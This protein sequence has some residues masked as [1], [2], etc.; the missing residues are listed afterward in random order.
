MTDREP[1]IQFEQVGK[2]YVTLDGETTALE[3]INFHVFRGEF[4][5][6]LGP[7][8]CGKSTILSLLAGLIKPT[9]GTVLIEQKPVTS[10]SRKIG[11]MLQQD[12]LLNWRTIEQNI[13]LGLEIQRQINDA[14]REYA[15]KLLDEM[16]LSDYRNYYPGQLSGGM[17][18]RVALTRTLATRPDIL[19]LDEPFSALDFTTRL[20]LE[21]LVVKTLR[22][23]KKTAILVTHDISE[24]I[25]MSDRILI[26]TG[27]PGQIKS[28]IH[29]PSALRDPLPFYSRDLPEFQNYFQNIW[30][31]MN[32]DE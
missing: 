30:K 23:H 18:Q 17:R 25:A 1:F 19:L 32:R 11:Y 20:R 4:V 5:T 2:T 3:N 29:I 22:K 27:R 31:V 24:A 7:S 15:L 13:L 10:P 21:D 28:E 26:L 14:N 12:Y 8:G 16:G 9:G 6:L